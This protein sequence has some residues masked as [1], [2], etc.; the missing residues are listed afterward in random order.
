[1]GSVRGIPF[2]SCSAG[3]VGLVR[4]PPGRSRR[5]VVLDA[6]AAVHF[7]A[8]VDAMAP[9]GALGQA[10]GRVGCQ[11]SGDGDYGIP[12]SL[13]WAMSYPNG[14]VPTTELVHPTPI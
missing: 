14:A 9:I 1:M 10:I 2:S 5:G 13:P 6:L 11:I 7:L 12:T 3:R 8:V 4:W